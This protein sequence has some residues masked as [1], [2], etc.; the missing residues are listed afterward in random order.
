MSILYAIL[1][2]SCVGLI[3]GVGLCAASY[4]WDTPVDEREA[5][6]REVLPGANCGGCGYSGCDAYAAALLEGTAKPNLCAP[7]GEETV[8][9]L[10]QILG[11]EAEEAQKRIAMVRCMGDCEKTTKAFQYDGVKTCAGANMYHGG[12]GACKYGCLGY[13][14]CVSACKF[15]AIKIVN[16][17]AEVIPENCTACGA[18]KSACPKRIINIVP[19]SATVLVACSNKDSAALSKPVCSVSC[20]GCGLC[21]KKCPSGAVEM[22]NNLPEIDYDKCTNCGECRGACPRKSII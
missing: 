2:V 12:D 17:K 8:K 5:A 7:G 20:I 13:G 22:K 11:V 18:C 21:A 19:A 16:G 3:A 1:I 15:D 9:N 10:S 4:F 6:I 14:D